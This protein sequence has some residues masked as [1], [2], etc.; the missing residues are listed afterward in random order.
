LSS[1]SRDRRTSDKT[2]HQHP[3][4]FPAGSVRFGPELLDT[5]TKSLHPPHVVDDKMRIVPNAA[6]PFCK[7]DGDD[8]DGTLLP[9]YGDKYCNAFQVNILHM[10]CV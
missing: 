4:D 2:S 3:D 1:T 10:V 9:E 6:F 5:M 8:T 7:Y